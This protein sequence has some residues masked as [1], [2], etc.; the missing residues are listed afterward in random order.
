[1]V[2]R[3]C[4]VPWRPTCGCQ[5]TRLCPRLRRD[6]ARFLEAPSS[7][8]WRGPAPCDAGRGGGGGP[9]QG[10]SAGRQL[11]EAARIAHTVLVARLPAGTVFGRSSFPSPGLSLPSV[12]N[13]SVPPNSPPF[14]SNSPGN[15]LFKSKYSPLLKQNPN[16]FGWHCGPFI[17]DSLTA[18]LL[19]S[20]LQYSDLALG[21]ICLV[22]INVTLSS[23]RPKV[24]NR[25]HFF[26]SLIL[27]FPFKTEG[28]GLG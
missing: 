28:L 11:D 1:M 4:Q 27:I 14:P 24:A 8:A 18:C 16:S 3:Q 12:L 25:T 9:G 6:L 21:T 22:L 17:V 15:R 19:P 7:V 13:F 10:P 5:A 20:R 23:P 26:P 2:T